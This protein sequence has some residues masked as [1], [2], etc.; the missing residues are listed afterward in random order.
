MLLSF[1][2]EETLY[3]MVF[4]HKSGDEYLT[5]FAGIGISDDMQHDPALVR[6]A[7][8]KAVEITAQNTDID[9]LMQITDDC[10]GQ[11]EDRTGFAE[12]NIHP[13][14]LKSLF[15][16]TS[17]KKMYAMGWVPFWRITVIRQ[18]PVIRQS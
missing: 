1:L 9:R 4:Y 15:P 2:V 11:Y 3:P 5:K 6:E 12:I 7:E 8:D 16:E 17:H 13:G 18:Q 10:A 14:R